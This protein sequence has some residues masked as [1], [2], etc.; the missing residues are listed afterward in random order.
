MS[1]LG[2]V[3]PS[4]YSSV[5]SSETQ[6]FQQLY[7][8]E[9]CRTKSLEKSVARLEAEAKELKAKAAK[10]AKELEAKATELGAKAKELDAL[11]VES[12]SK[13]KQLQEL[14]R[15]LDN[16]DRPASSG[17]DEKVRDLQAANIRLKES[18]TRIMD[19]SK[20]VI[21]E[22]Q[23]E[24][25]SLK[26]EAQ[27]RHDTILGLDKLLATQ[28]AEVMNMLSVERSETEARAGV[29]NKVANCAAMIQK[30][31]EKM[32]IPD[33]S[34]QIL[35]PQS[36]SSAAPA[37]KAVSDS[38]SKDSQPAKPE[39]KVALKDEDE[40]RITE[41]P[42]AATDDFLQ[43]AKGKSAPAT[44]GPKQEAL[45]EKLASSNSFAAL[46]DD[47]GQTSKSAAQVK[48]P[49]DIQ[50][51]YPKLP[52]IN[53]NVEKRDKEVGN[54]SRPANA[55]NALKTAPQTAGQGQGVA[56]GQEAARGGGFA[57][58]RGFGEGR[59][60]GEGRGRGG[61]RGKGGWRGRS[62]GIVRGQERDRGLERGRASGRG[63][64]FGRG[65]G[66][67]RETTSRVRAVM[68][69]EQQAT[70]SMPLP[71]TTPRAWT[72]PLPASLRNAAATHP[73]AT[74]P[75][76]TN[77]AV[78]NPA[79]TNAAAAKA[80]ATRPAAANAAAT[81]TASEPSRTMA[82]VAVDPPQPQAQAGMSFMKMMAEK[83]AAEARAAKK[84][85]ISDKKK[86]EVAAAGKIVEPGTPK[87][88]TQPGPSAINLGDLDEEAGP[89]PKQWADMVDD[90]ADAADREIHLSSAE[91]IVGTEILPPRNGD[92]P[93]SGHGQEKDLPRKRVPPAPSV[94]SSTQDLGSAESEPKLE[95]RRLRET[96]H[97]RPS[98]EGW[99]VFD[100]A[101]EDEEKKRKAEEDAAAGLQ[102]ENVTEVED[103]KPG[104]E[105]EPEPSTEA[106]WQGFA[107]LEPGSQLPN[108]RKSTP[109][110]TANKP[111]PV[112]TANKRQDLLRE[113]ML[114]YVDTASPPLSPN[115]PHGKGFVP[116]QMVAEVLVN[117]DV[118][119]NIVDDSKVDPKS[120]GEASSD[121]APLEV[122]G[123]GTPVPDAQGE[124]T[125]DKAVPSAREASEL[126]K[127]PQEPHRTIH[128]KKDFEDEEKFKSHPVAPGRPK[129]KERKRLKQAKA[130]KAAK[131]DD[132]PKPGQ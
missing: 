77:P 85:K 34:T 113:K 7:A 37:G 106:S 104:E 1:P 60:S 6:N 55:P 48:K 49:T 84:S 95:R 2:G 114:E 89:M 39:A 29:V 94:S 52:V 23:A 18:I 35:R 98:K 105:K 67:G 115:H 103:S 122:T 24:I 73:A 40:I 93:A 101:K 27:E 110:R 42:Q 75:A 70:A 8:A 41:Q 130:A 9:Q 10:A 96:Q 25:S 97:I 63:R 121:K 47:N 76:A 102:P 14:Q 88:R 120:T 91:A 57:E 118:Y 38:R 11:Q 62:K 132:G 81:S 100:K 19:S 16:A 5:M 45:H 87:A 90:P 68:S 65:R 15:V 46:A 36:S 72:Q 33:S 26:E 71:P 21:N 111:T 3:P 20:V 54:A 59:G 43:P 64:G 74:H 4:W 83:W 108:R 119:K 126:P 61:W 80:A 92:I 86:M 69:P 112:S 107:G 44:R 128:G 131:G 116:P 22:L 30:K 123:Q 129:G 109:A 117:P 82:Q 50:Q 66:S 56:Q 99:I 78:T 124:G 53:T 127:S 58:G 51:R 32:T 12:G 125:A 17:G 13:D 28:T 79:A 31:R